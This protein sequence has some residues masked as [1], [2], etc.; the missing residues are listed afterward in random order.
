MLCPGICA[1]SGDVVANFGVLDSAYGL[2]YGTAFGTLS[3]LFSC[4]LGGS[5]VLKCFMRY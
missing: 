2:V 3:L 4:R 5:I 1:D